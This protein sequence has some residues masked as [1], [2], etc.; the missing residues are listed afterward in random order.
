MKRLF[1]PQS[2]IPAMLSGAK[3]QHRV[4]IHE[5]PPDDATLEACIYHLTR[6]RKD[7]EEYPGPATFGCFTPDGDRALPCPYQPGEEVWVGEGLHWQHHQGQCTHGIQHPDEGSTL[8]YNAD[9]VEVEQPPDWNPRINPYTGKPCGIAAQR[10]P[11]WAARIVRRVRAVRVERVQDISEAD[12]AAEGCDGRCPVGYI[13]AHQS[14]P[15]A[16][17]FAQMWDATHGPGAWTRNDWV[18]VLDLEAKR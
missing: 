6:V 1:V 10:M 16:Y 8:H 9:D 4:L 11:R 5:Q 13:P 15:H 7:G 12:A 17:H 2:T 18:W 14:G 3:T